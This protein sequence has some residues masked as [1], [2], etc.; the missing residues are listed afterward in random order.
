MMLRKLRTFLPDWLLGAFCLLI[1]ALYNSFP[2]VTS[3]SGGYISNAY[4]LYLPIDRPVG[5]S[6]FVRLTSMGTSLW[7]VVMAQALLLAALML[8]IARHA[9]GAAY[10]RNV[11]VVVMLLMGVATSAGW[12]CGQLTPDVFTPIMLLALCVLMFLPCTALGKWLLYA[13]LVGCM[14]IHNS[15]LLIGIV[16]SLVLIV[17]GWRRKRRVL[18]KSGMALIALSA[19]AWLSLSAMNAI[20]GRGFRPSSASHVFLM[21]RMVEN[22]IAQTYLKD[23]CPSEPSSLCAYKDQLPD[24]Q[25]SFMWDTN[26]ALYKAGGWQATEAEYTHII[27]KT[28]T[29]PKYLGMHIFKNAEATLR[30]LPLIYVGEEL[31][32]LRVGTS[33]YKSIQ[34]YYSDELNEYRTSFQQRD[35]LKLEHWNELIVLFSLIVCIAALLWKG[36]RE[37]V[38]LLRR[39]TWLTIIFVLLNAA[40]TATFATVVARYEARVFWVLPFLATLNIL[41][42]YYAGKE[43]YEEHVNI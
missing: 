27:T 12:T 37:D 22:G 21:S 7:L 16:L 42:R 41:R 39:L 34:K 17:Y 19:V 20:A 29:T 36:K 43:V 24:R 4:T 30:Q 35:R 1:P 9:L 2:L 5:Y 11:F 28:L 31:A 15:N 6:V 10:R 3:D 38:S 26:G 14:L 13:L 33:P 25:W 32:A 8:I 23:R 40:L 18:Y